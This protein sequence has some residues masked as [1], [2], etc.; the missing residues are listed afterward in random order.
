MLELIIK[1]YRYLCCCSY[2]LNALLQQQKLNESYEQ[3]AAYLRYTQEATEV[4][5]NA[6]GVSCCSNSVTFG[7]FICTF[8]VSICVRV[9][10]FCRL[11]LK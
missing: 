3:S 11:I 5:K 9:I 6:V 8:T 10:T 7:T 2:D 4:I 1:L